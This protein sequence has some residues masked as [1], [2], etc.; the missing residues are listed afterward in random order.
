MKM[1]YRL[2][3]AA[4][5]ILCQLPSKVKADSLSVIYAGIQTHYGFIIPHSKS[6]EKVSNTNPFG[7]ELSFN[8]FHNSFKDLHVF[9]T[10]WISGIKTGYF[11]F[12]NSPLLG[13]ALTLTFF[14][15]PFISFG[16]KYIV[17][18][19]GGAGFSYHNKIYDPTGNPENLFFSTK[20]SFPLYVQ[21]R[22]KYK[23]YDK[24]FL[25]LSG[26][27]NHI[28][29]GGMKLP[30]KG[31]NFPTLAVGLEY[32]CKPFPEIQKFSSP[33]FEPKKGISLTMQVLTSVKVL[34]ESAG[35]P[36]QA[37]FIYGLHSRISKQLGHI[38]AINS[39]AEII[40]DGYLKESLKREQLDVD[41]KRFAL[42]F[43]QDF[44]FGQVIFTQYLGFYI[45][46]PYK[47]RNSVYQK[48]EFSYMIN[49]NFLV[50]VYLK[51]H[52]QVADLMGICINYQL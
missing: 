24:S 29:N 1:I 8:K 16:E 9:G 30:N 11:N 13:S 33:P 2:L 35:Y 36:E 6:I 22:I 45:Y 43:G 5:L 21:A 46:S 38:Y 3:L 23:L 17:T 52:M 50:G 51:A 12:Q 14:A 27:Y 42:T 4:L 48:Y 26:C 31:M 19:Q 20:I 41:Y 44:L 34:N 37:Y 49:E 39:G 47:A 7:F 25:T 40:F 32:F 18:I 28:S 15:E 10:Y